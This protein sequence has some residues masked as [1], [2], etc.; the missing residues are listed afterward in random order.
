MRSSHPLTLASALLVMAGAVLAAAALPAFRGD[1]RPG[2]VTTLGA[3][4]RPT[5]AGS[6]LAPGPLSEEELEAE[7]ALYR[8]AAEAAW[9]YLRRNRARTGLV[10]ATEHYDNV[11][12][13]DSGS[14]LL[15][16]HAAAELGLAPRRE[17]D[18]WIATLL[19]TLA[20]MPLFDDRVFNKSYSAVTA[21]MVGANDRPSERG[22]G[23]SATD[24]GRLL[25][26]LKVVETR[27]PAL[28]EAARRVVERLDLGRVVEDGYLHGEEPRG[29]GA[30]SRYQEGHIGY[31][32]YAA[33]GFQLW[34]H[35][36]E[37]ALDPS[38]NGVPVEVLGQT[39]LADRRGNDKLTSEPFVLMGMEL[40]WT[41]PFRELAW[42]M[43]A[44]QEARYRET[45]QVTMV[46]ED[47]IQTAPHYFYY[48]SVY[49]D[50][51]TFV[52]RAQ[53]PVENGPRWV[54]A[55]AAYAWH[56]LLPTEY[57]W[58]AVQTVEPARSA[59]GW[60]SGVFEGTGETTAVRN[61]N[62]AGIILEAALYR[63]RGRPLLDEAGDQTD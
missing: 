2:V 42:R 54:S 13:W 55:K 58:L 16:L 18:A 25:I 1:E 7:D 62:T 43:L 28:A 30:N 15:G 26:A 5:L 10:S 19:E 27:H 17:V 4:E 32:Q 22:K 24:L 44:V 14:L 60:A 50:G 56:A 52:V 45:G 34:G 38:V 11:T 47:A 40:G 9:A 21:R 12:T 49:G 29:R 36:A 20:T 3:L 31:E 48:Y 8:S 41:P 6:A 59:D 61:V 37:A 57:T 46:S 51:E 23:W 53:G 35:T 39:I 33:R 63:A